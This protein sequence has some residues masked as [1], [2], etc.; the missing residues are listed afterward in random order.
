[1]YYS[2]SLHDESLDFFESFIREII[3]GKNNYKH[4]VEPIITD[5]HLYV[6]GEKDIYSVNRSGFTVIVFLAKTATDFFKTINPEN[7]SANDYDY[8]L[9][10]ISS[11]RETARA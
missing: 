6:L 11:Q 10:V 5:T 4:L 3:A 2:H 8:I 7:V 1:M 9:N